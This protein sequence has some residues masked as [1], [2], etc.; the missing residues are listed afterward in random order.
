MGRNHTGPPCS[1]DHPHGR[2]T[3]PLAALQTT[4]TDAIK[5][6][7][8]GPTVIINGDC[9][10]GHYY[11]RRLFT[12]GDYLALIQHLSHELGQLWQWMLFIATGNCCDWWLCIAAGSGRGGGGDANDVGDIQLL[13]QQLTASQSKPH[14]HD[15]LSASS[16]HTA[17]VSQHVPGH[18]RQHRPGQPHLISIN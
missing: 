5:Q 2:P 1:V 12:A 18:R 9:G 13:S 8:T 6:N 17:A 4:T 7:N 10:C 14:L 15:A 11:S 3:R 16:L